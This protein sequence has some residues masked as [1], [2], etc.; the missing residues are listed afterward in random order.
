[1]KVLYGDRR[2]GM[3]PILT[4]LS[5]DVSRELKLV[6]TNVQVDNQRRPNVAE[7]LDLYLVKS[8]VTRLRLMLNSILHTVATTVQIDSSLRQSRDP[9]FTYNVSTTGGLDI[10]IQFLEGWVKVN[11]ITAVYGSQGYQG[12]IQRASPAPNNPSINI[13]KE[14]KPFWN[15]PRMHMGIHMDWIEEQLEDEL[16]RD[17]I[18]IIIPWE[19]LG[20]LI[21]KV[22]ASERKL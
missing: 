18:I 10:P 7:G 11:Q 4:V 13:E 20:Q 22:T 12:K 21:G 2:N 9:R 16:S 15:E 3:N 17:E 5:D 6:I 14:H 1:M 19:E 8:E